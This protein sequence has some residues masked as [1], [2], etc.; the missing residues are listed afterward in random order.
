MSSRTTD[1]R[2]GRP[3]AAVVAI[4]AIAVGI[5]AAIG[6]ERR[7]M[8]QDVG[9]DAGPVID[10]DTAPDQ[11][12]ADQWRFRVGLGV[13]VRPDYIGSDDYEAVP[14]PQF[15]ASRGTQYVNITGS[16]LFSN[17]VP[18]SNWR[19]GP[20]AKFLNGGD[21]C[22]A[23]DNRVSDMRCQA[24]ALM[25]GATGGYAFPIPGLAGRQAKLTP[26]LE[27]LGDVAGANDGV[28]IEPQLN[29][30]QLLAADWRLGL[31]AFGTWGSDDFNDYTFGVSRFDAQRSGLPRYSADAGFYQTG[32][33]GA[34]D[35]DLTEAW[36][37]SVIG[38]YTR[39]VG[40]AEDS[41]IV[42]GRDAQ[43]SANQFLA[44]LIVSYVW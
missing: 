39:L 7:A 26:A 3:D 21:R 2:A 8:A 24:N 9:I 22:N 13:G 16:Y 40:D 29:Y 34:V 38:R 4:L 36:R 17:L 30:A 11:A 12:A 27:I 10:P 44:G 32:L 15:T 20:T 14:L 6:V 35:Y 43:G 37:L 41:P 33:L 5:G 1:E 25:L 42:D 31:R 18:S 19:L 28:T 23:D